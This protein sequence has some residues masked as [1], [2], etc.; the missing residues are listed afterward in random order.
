MVRMFYIIKFL[1]IILAHK[2]IVIKFAFKMPFFLTCT[3]LLVIGLPVFC[4]ATGYG[5]IY[6]DYG[7]QASGVLLLMLLALDLMKQ[8][9]K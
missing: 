3:L 9:R 8:R 6:L 1:L 5:Q 4:F 7:P 2:T